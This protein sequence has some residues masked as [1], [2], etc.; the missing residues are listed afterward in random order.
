MPENFKYG[1]CKKCGRICVD[2][3]HHN[4]PPTWEVRHEDTRIYGDEWS[5]PIY[6]F[7]AET[8][9]EQFAERYDCTS[10]EYGMIRDEQ[11]V[12]FEVRSVAD[13]ST[14]T[15]VSVCAESQPTYTGRVI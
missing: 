3:L 12:T 14:V 13:P 15:R 6:A 9:A 8:A 10:G 11:A 7:D 2:L 5:S 1:D 4:C